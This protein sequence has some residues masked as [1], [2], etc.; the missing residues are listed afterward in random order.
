[1]KRRDFLKL[2][3]SAPLLVHADL[4]ARENTRVLPEAVGLLYDATLCINCQSCVSACKYVNQMAPDL[5]PQPL[6]RSV[7]GRRGQQK[8]DADAIDVWVVNDDLS[9][10]TLSVV[11]RHDWGNGK[12]KNN[13][14][15]GHSFLKRQCMHCV[16][17]SCVSACPVSAMQ[18]DPVSG[19]VSHDPKACIGC[20]YCV[21]ACPF[22][23]PQFEFE[24]AFGQ[25]QK[26]QLCNQP[27]LNRLDQGQLPACA[28]VCPV[29][30]TLFGP[31]QALLIEAKKRLDGSADLDYDFPLGQL[32][33]GEFKRQPL[34]RYHQHIYG[35]NEGGGTQVLYLAAVPFSQLALPAL[36]ARSAASRS[37]S[38]QRKMTG[39]LPLV[40]LAGLLC[41][42]YRRRIQAVKPAVSKTNGA[43]LT[44]Q[45][46]KFNSTDSKAV[47]DYPAEKKLPELA[48]SHRLNTA[49]SSNW[50][51]A[52]LATLA[53]LAVLILAY[54]IFFGLGAVTNLSNQFPWGLWVVLDVVIGSA[55]ACGGLAISVVIL[56]FNRPA[57][58]PLLRPAL[59]TSLFGYSLA[60]LSAFFDMGRYWQ[61]ANLLNPHYQNWNS[62]I[63]EVSLCISAYCLVLLLELSPRWLNRLGWFQ[64]EGMVR[65]LMFVFLAFG[66]LLA[67]LHQASLGSLLILVDQRVM[68]LWQSGQLTPLLTLL[69]ALMTGGAV[70]VFETSRQHHHLSPERLKLRHQL[71]S[72]AAI[73]ALIFILI[74]IFELFL[75][76]KLSSLFEQP[77]YSILLLLEVLLFCLPGFILRLTSKAGYLNLAMV[78]VLLASVLYRFNLFMFAFAPSL[79]NRYS[80]SLAEWFVSAGLIALELLIFRLLLTKDTYREANCS[81]R[82]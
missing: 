77:G 65:R 1:M 79:Q 34:G 12:S 43:A 4:D 26:C 27:G 11:Q 14:I 73:L 35:E 25:I 66:L 67:S 38:L 19:I 3:G 44:G 57:F 53:V 28:E 54:R 49:P 21:A 45:E 58:R 22:A 30:A 75:N 69:S 10:K 56:L 82:C 51:T 72:G 47:S 31:R 55:F 39:G 6:T 13:P 46:P 37:E 24:Q 71:G 7:K 60:G 59:L 52:L 16:D 80:P 18:K 29:G 70:V 68:P 9:S 23:I 78:F 2:S 20:R 41:L 8:T 48:A 5:V 33:S 63:L 50:L 62:V 42:G 15:D 40:A 81:P 76:N 74:R 32:G 64:L 36:D 61:L 17:P